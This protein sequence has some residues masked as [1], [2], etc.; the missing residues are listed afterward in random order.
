MN[1]QSRSLCLAS[2]IALAISTASGGAIAATAAQEVI[3]ARQETQIWT[4]YTLSPYLRAN[5]LEVTVDNGK[6]TL[7]GNVAEDVN[8][9]LAKEIALGVK[10][11]TEVDNRIVVNADYQPARPGTERSFGDTIDDAGITAQIKSK[12]MW[13]KNTDGMATN[14]DTRFG[15]VTLRGTAQSA[16]ERD[17]AGRMA[18]NTPGVVALDN[19]IKV[20]ALR[21]TIA[22]NSKNMTDEAGA[23]MADSWITTKVKSTLLYSSNVSG[24]AIDVTTSK[25]IVS[26]SGTV[27]NGAEH[28]LAIELAQNVRGVRSVQ[29]K[30]LVF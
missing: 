7:T 25:G 18:T 22:E 6:A 30:E 10:G 4:T 5:D 16:A 9:D 27:S 1:K 3:N 21:P 2:A 11:I 19:Q 20:N 29:S 13:G 28:D 17:L 14:V 8:K 26:L 15:R 24:S 12:L 23:D